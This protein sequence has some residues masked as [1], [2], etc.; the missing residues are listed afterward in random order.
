[1]GELKKFEIMGISLPV[2][3]LITALVFVTMMLGWMP[4]GMIGAFAVMMVFGG[5]FN[6]I[7]NH[8]PIVKTY[9]GGGAIV[10]I[11]ASAALVTFGVI[12]EAV[13]ESVDGFM[14]TTGFLNF[15]IAALITGSILGMNRSLL[16]RAAVRFLPV[17]LCAMTFAILAV[18]FVGMIMGYGFADAVMYVA[19]PMMGG[20]MGAGVVPLS[21]MYAEA[22]GQES[23]VIISR[24][25][26]A[27]TL[28]NVCAIV[29]AGLLAKLGE[30]KPGLTGN[31]K[32]MRK[33]VEEMTDSEM[34]PTS[35]QM[36]GIGMIL[37]LC[38]YLVGTIINK[39]VPSI[40]T[41]AWMI[42]AVAASK[43][44][45]I[46][47]SKFEQAAKQW[48][49]FV[50]GNWTQALLVGIGI[51]MI[52]LNAVASAFSLTYMILV[53]VVVGGVALGA[54]VGGYLVGFYPV[55]SS[56]TAG[57]CTT[58]MGGTGDIAVLS[59]ARRMELLPFAQIATRICGALILIVASVLVKVLL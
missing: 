31:G 48:S 3:L 1:M 22:L 35:V 12:P 46:I 55:E 21:G 30:V 17:A 38:F 15:Y 41:Y 26:P 13:I 50:M 44:L 59:A 4:K 16:L 5:L 53:L 56:I 37:A 49:G 18:G 29:G 9:L 19:I 14:N 10:C 7:G 57:L 54:G 47:P 23:A 11:F 32:L 8:T 51:S 45:G 28:G 43:A 36:M 6:T 20:G 42:I 27:S 2:Y 52:D 24:M 25:I 40:H 33:D 39:L 34:L 58:N